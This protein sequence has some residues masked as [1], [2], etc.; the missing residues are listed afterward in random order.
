MTHLTTYV[1]RH[2]CI[3]MLLAHLA[4]YKHTVLSSLHMP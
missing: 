3:G 4:Y 1:K 2:Y